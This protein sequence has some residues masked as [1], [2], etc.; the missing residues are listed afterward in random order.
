MRKV[1]LED[2][3]IDSS[4]RRYLVKHQMDAGGGILIKLEISLNFAVKSRKRRLHEN[5]FYTPWRLT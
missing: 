1:Q 5:E 3:K 2:I 4:S